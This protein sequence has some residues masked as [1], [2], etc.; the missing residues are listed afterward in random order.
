MARMVLLG[1]AALVAVA[2]PVIAPGQGLTATVLSIGDGDTIR[3]RQAG[4][5][6]TVRRACWPYGLSRLGGINAGQPL[7]AAASADRS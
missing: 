2:W 7:C 5:E 4:R 6:I 3:V 1:V